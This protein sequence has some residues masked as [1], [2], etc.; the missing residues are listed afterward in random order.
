MSKM[1]WRP[2]IVQISF[3]AHYTEGL[4]LMPK[5]RDPCHNYL[6]ACPKNVQENM[7][8]PIEVRIGL[9]LFRR[10]KNF[11][12]WFTPLIVTKHTSLLFRSKVEGKGKYLWPHMVTKDARGGGVIGQKLHLD[13]RDLPDM[14][15]NRESWDYSFHSF[16]TKGIRKFSNGHMVKA[17]H[18]VISPDAIAIKIKNQRSYRYKCQ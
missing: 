12:L 2:Q 18:Q 9:G 15:R 5:M 11:G 16:G 6:M 14:A 4:Y 1:F 7:G 17:W 3:I 13:H 10:S 8:W